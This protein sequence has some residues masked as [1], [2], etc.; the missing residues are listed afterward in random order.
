MALC[1][2]GGAREWIGEDA[3]CFLHPTKMGIFIFL[4]A[5][6]S[7]SSAYAG[8]GSRALVWM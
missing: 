3:P 7:I 2:V 5:Q 8:S 1:I 6:A 4:G